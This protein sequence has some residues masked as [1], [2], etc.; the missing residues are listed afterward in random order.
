MTGAILECLGKLLFTPSEEMDPSKAV[1]EYGMDSMIAAELRNWFVKSFGTDVTVLELLNPG[2]KISDL[3]EVAGVWK[4]CNI[5]RNV[6]VG[7]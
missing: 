5:T 4:K 6:I 7:D 2:T 1:S 3:V